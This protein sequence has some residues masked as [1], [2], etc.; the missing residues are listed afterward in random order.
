MTPG[1]RDL[2]DGSASILVPLRMAPTT[3]KPPGSFFRIRRRLISDPVLGWRG[4]RVGGPDLRIPHDFSQIRL[5]VPRTLASVH[6]A[7]SQ[8]AHYTHD[9]TVRVV[10]QAACQTDKARANSRDRKLATR[11]AR[12]LLV[13][14]M[15]KINLRSRAASV[16]LAALCVPASEPTLLTLPSHL[17][18]PL[19]MAHVLR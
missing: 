14:S 6:D 19:P 18:A 1:L 10:R 16:S 15:I 5:A 3:W 12:R 7:R 11:G 17:D 2:L 9:L 13:P 8:P 4:P